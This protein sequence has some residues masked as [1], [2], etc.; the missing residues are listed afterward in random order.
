MTIRE[1][2]KIMKNCLHHG[3]TEF[4]KN[5]HC[6]EC[7]KYERLRKIQEKR[8]LEKMRRNYVR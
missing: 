8:I 4:Y 5:G 7:V 1:K 2:E 6:K 3:F